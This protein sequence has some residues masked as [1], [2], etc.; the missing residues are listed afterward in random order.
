MQLGRGNTLR[1]SMIAAQNYARG[2]SLAAV[3][4][5]NVEVH[6][7]N[8]DK[9]TAIQA[10]SQDFAS[11]GAPTC[12]LGHNMLCSRTGAQYA[13]GAQVSVMGH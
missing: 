3:L 7:V 1:N 13:A 10:R 8:I 5:G 2:G 4:Q 11:D 6:V 9:C 12:L